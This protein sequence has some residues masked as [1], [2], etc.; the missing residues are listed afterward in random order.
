M[1]IG[2]S[3]VMKQSF[4]IND[5]AYWRDVVCAQ[6]LRGACPR[7][8]PAFNIDL[9]VNRIEDIQFSLLSETGHTFSRREKHIRD[10][11]R[12]EFAV[13]VPLRGGFVGLHD[14][15]EMVIEEGDLGCADGTRP[16]EMTLSS[17]FELLLVQLPQQTLVNAPGPTERYTGYSLKKKTPLGSLLASFLQ[18]PRTCS[19][20]PVS[21]CCVPAGANGDR[22]HPDDLGG[23]LFH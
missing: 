23:R 14:G 6:L 1:P 17:N 2:R 20:T 21:F 13:L 12:D 9:T 16:G 8:E 15:R 22:P 11:S 5:V 3:A 4:R 19:R 10:S 7:V 18:K